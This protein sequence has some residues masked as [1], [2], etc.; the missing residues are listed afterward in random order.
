[1]P[2]LNKNLH[3]NLI[4]KPNS[5]HSTY[6]R[7]QKAQFASEQRMQLWHF[8]NLSKL[9]NF[10]FCQQKPTNFYLI[11]FYKI[12]SSSQKPRKM[13]RNALPN[14]KKSKKFQFASQRKTKKCSKLL[15]K[16]SKRN[17][18]TGWNSFWQSV[19]RSGLRLTLY[20]IETTMR[21]AN[22]LKNST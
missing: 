12:S 6:S 17:L 5:N 7:L 1:M 21:W 19:R 10:R 13:G 14:H 15:H 18:L 9:H 22:Y 16:I 2:S 20:W 8:S 3:T 4:H 11:R